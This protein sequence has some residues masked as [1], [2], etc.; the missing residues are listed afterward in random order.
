ADGKLSLERFVD[1]TSAGPARV[2]GIVGKGRIVVGYDADLTVIDRKAYWV[3]D[4]S[5]IVS[6][7]GWTP[8]AGKSVWGLPRLPIIGGRIV[9]RDG[10]LIGPPAGQPVRFQECLPA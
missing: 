10:E 6:R 1:L 3:I 8:F 2:F 5:W 4:D 7:C 9:M